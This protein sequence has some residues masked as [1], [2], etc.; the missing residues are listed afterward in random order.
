MATKLSDAKPA[1]PKGAK[2]AANPGAAGSAKPKPAPVKPA[3]AKPAVPAPV[4]SAAGLVVKPAA[5]VLKLKDLM[6][7]VAEATGGK[8]KDLK[9][10][11]EAVLAGM[12]RALADGTELNLPPFGKAKVSRRKDDVLVI[13]LKRGSGEKSGK[14]DMSEGV[15]AAED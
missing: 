10:V 8:R 5:N 9:E 11:I 6:D 7:Q 14:K 2:K 12:G 1:A 3:S 4:E 13:K 15:A